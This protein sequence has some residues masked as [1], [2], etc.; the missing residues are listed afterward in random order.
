MTPRERLLSE[1]RSQADIEARARDDATLLQGIQDLASSV[2]RQGRLR[3]TG[4]GASYHAG[5][6][7]PAML[8]RHGID[9]DCVITSDLL[10][11]GAA[12]WDAPLL[13]ISQSGASAE[14]VALLDR[15][16]SLPEL[17]GLTLDAGSPLGRARSLVV[18]GGPEQAYAAT[19]SFTGTLDALLRLVSAITG[20]DTAL[21]RG[22]RELRRLLEQAPDQGTVIADALGSAGTIVTTGRGPLVGVAGYAALVIMELR[23]E[24]SM[25]LEAAQLR[26][27]PLE[28]LDHHVGLIVLRADGPTTGLLD[29]LI[30]DAAKAGGPIVVVDAGQADAPRA[31]NVT[32]LRM[33]PL[34]EAA[35]ALA[36]PVV[37]QSAAMILAERAG[38][39]PGEALHATKVTRQ[40]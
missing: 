23:R 32:T 11:Y 29:R 36:S 28:A 24:P 30:Q 38:L 15:R 22:H 5:T 33:S 13:A 16:A 2:R 37:L 40:L 27:G 12:A 20:E 8:G 21:E 39:Q 18:A 9:T 35:A 34:P 25:A 4:M 19:R 10:N 3:V 14:I 26:H 1:M 7:L 6:L 31:P 17:W